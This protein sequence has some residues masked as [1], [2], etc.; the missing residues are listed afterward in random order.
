M[1]AKGTIRLVARGKIYRS[2][3]DFVESSASQRFSQSSGIS[4]RTRPDGEWSLVAR[5]EK[6]RVRAA[7]P[8]EV[9]VLAERTVGASWISVS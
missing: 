5:A 1:S 9:S 8:A 3:T 7:E 4:Y 2:V 6:S